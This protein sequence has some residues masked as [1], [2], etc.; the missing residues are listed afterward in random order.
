MVKLAVVRAGVALT[1]VG[2]VLGIL[3]I[4]AEDWV[5][6]G[7]FGVE[8]CA[9]D[10]ETPLAS[11]GLYSAS[12]RPRCADGSAVAESY[13]SMSPI[14]STK[15]T[16]FWPLFPAQNNFGDL[17][18]P[19][20]WSGSC[21][22]SF[23][24]G[25]R[26]RNA[27][28]AAVLFQTETKIFASLD[29]PLG[30]MAQLVRATML[31]ATIGFEQS[32]LGVIKDSIM[33]EVSAGLEDLAQ[34]ALVPLGALNVAATAGWVT[35]QS[36]DPFALDATLTSQISD[37]TEAVSNLFGDVNQLGY[38]ALTTFCQIA[39]G[40]LSSVNNTAPDASAS[41]ALNAIDAV[42]P[43]TKF[44]EQVDASGVNERAAILQVVL[45]GTYAAMLVLSH[46][47]ISCG[48]TGASITDTFLDG[49]VSSAAVATEYT[50]NTTALC[51]VSAAVQALGAP[52]DLD[53]LLL[54]FTVCAGETLSSCFGPQ[55]AW[56]FPADLATPGHRIA[57]M[58]VNQLADFVALQSNLTLSGTYTA[59]DVIKV[60]GAAIE[61]DMFETITG[62]ALS[63][64]DAAQFLGMVQLLE[65][66]AALGLPWNTNDVSNTRSCQA[67]LFNANMI[68]TLLASGTLDVT[69]AQYQEQFKLPE[70][71]TLAF[72]VCAIPASM[73][74]LATQQ[75][76][77]IDTQTC[78]FPEFLGAMA[79]LSTLDGS[80]ISDAELK[81]AFDEVQAGAVAMLPVYLIVNYCNAGGLRARADCAAG[82]QSSALP[83][84]LASTEPAV[85]QFLEGAEL[86]VLEGFYSYI[87]T[88]DE[89]QV[90]C[91]DNDLDMK[92]IANAQAMM[93]VGVG[94]LSVSLLLG[95]IV[96]ANPSKNMALVGGLLSIGGAVAMMAGFLMIQGAPMSRESDREPVLGDTVAVSGSGVLL[97]MA[98][99][100][101][102]L[103]AGLLVVGGA[104]CDN[105]SKNANGV[106][107]STH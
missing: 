94:C 82:L 79:L 47:Y 96:A 10:G 22:A 76:S 107:P 65:G 4:L 39:L 12:F 28:R 34:A 17:V 15:V 80:G 77:G 33:E 50:M 95:S 75:P 86:M 7:L 69:D 51:A 37:G 42:V 85:Q 49:L 5:R 61:A 6:V 81:A 45:E 52:S 48:V 102:G 73:I 31:N 40:E 27:A 55:T 91:E 104:L 100:G 97:G 11:V 99:L 44:S 20:A 24:P 54:T 68:P 18:G 62:S 59:V 13:A 83:G 2:L 14:E 87:T 89:A 53:G 74:E 16:E 36:A 78:T 63:A 66:C 70:D 60:L 35:P 56:G 93:A 106:A 19:E 105:R 26:T 21:K 72:A 46:G 23:E 98:G 58:F 88:L 38:A 25:S 3:S 92:A 64:S 84:F 43:G 101:A 103:I 71:W 9:N 57:T 29:A 32:T 90:K 1:L 30:G 8:G 41:T 67:A